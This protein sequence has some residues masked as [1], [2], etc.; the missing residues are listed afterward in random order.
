PKSNIVAPYRGHSPGHRAMA[1]AP[2]AN[3]F[4]AAAAAQAPGL[5]LFDYSADEVSNCSNLY[6]M[7][8]QW[9][10]NMHQAGINNLVTMRPT[11]AL[12]N[13]GSGTG[14]SAVDIWGVLPVMYD[15][16]KT[17]VNEAL[18]KGDAVWS[19]NDTVQDS[20]SPKWEI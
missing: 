7:I 5:P 12:F 9:A 3:Q 1:P 15:G 18:Q 13:D 20:Y 19:Y 10:Y 16:A 6:S 4:Q 14:R 11:R 2:P 17:Y 8:R